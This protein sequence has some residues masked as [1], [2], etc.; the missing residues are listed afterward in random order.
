MRE[1]LKPSVEVITF[2]EEDIITT[3]GGI[4]L[5]EEEL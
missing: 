4:T 5:P 2:S 1:F 3:S